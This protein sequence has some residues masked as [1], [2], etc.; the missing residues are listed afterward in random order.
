MIGVPN[1]PAM[2]SAAMA[3]YWKDWRNIRKLSPGAFTAWLS[4]HFWSLA[5]WWNTAT[6]RAFSSDGRHHNSMAEQKNCHRLYRSENLM[7]WNIDDTTICFST[8]NRMCNPFCEERS[9]LTFHLSN[10]LPSGKKDIWL[11]EK[12]CRRR[13]DN[14]ACDGKGKAMR[15]IGKGEDARQWQTRKV[16]IW[17]TGG[18][19]KRRPAN[20]CKYRRNQT[21]NILVGTVAA[22]A[23]VLCCISN[24]TKQGSNHS[25]DPDMKTGMWRTYSGILEQTSSWLQ[26]MPFILKRKHLIL[27]S[28]SW[29]RQIF[30][31]ST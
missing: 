24:H 10:Q 19:I 31:E 12:P 13:K 28:I 29:R 30:P 17:L 6:K 22:P 11:A 1:A 26:N 21:G 14:K 16:C 5:L 23:V 27:K 9:K 25:K 3:S 18:N 20:D 8:T 7:G 15:N 4:Q 2:D